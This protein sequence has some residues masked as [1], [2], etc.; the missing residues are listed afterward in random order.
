MTYFRG[1]LSMEIGK[2]TGKQTESFSQR[3]FCCR[4]IPEKHT[5]DK[6]RGRACDMGRSL[7]LDGSSEWEA[8]DILAKF[9]GMA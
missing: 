1:P 4:I 3:E 6:Q 8:T 7:V 5:M 2:T 9:D